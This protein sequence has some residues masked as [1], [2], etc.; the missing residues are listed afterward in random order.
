MDSA[1]DFFDRLGVPEEK[2]EVI[3]TKLAEKL[4][5]EPKIGIFGKTGVGKSS[6]CNALFGQD[7]CPISDIESCTRNPQEV[8]LNTGGRGIKLLDVP[9]VGENQSKDE[10]YGKLYV[11]LLPKLDLVLW[12]LKGDDRAFSSD[13]LFY[14]AIVKPH[15]SEGK[16]FFFVINQVDKIEPYKEWNDSEHRPGVNQFS[17][18]DKKADA[19]SRAFECPKSWVIPVSAN[20][21]YNLDVLV[22]TFIYALPKEKVF[23]VGRQVKKGLI[24]EGTREKIESSWFE[25]VKEV[26]EG[27]GEVLH[28]GK[29]VVKTVGET[30]WKAGKSIIKH[31]IGRACFITTAT[32]ESLG[33]PDDCYE[34]NAFRSFRDNWL[35][36]Q[37]DGQDLTAEYYRI[38]PHIVSE[39]NR[40]PDKDAVYASIWRNHLAEC[41][42]LIESERYS[43]CKEK[44]VEMVNTLKQNFLNDR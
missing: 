13:E 26:F 22:D 33:R 24:S 32:C 11:K 4:S 15:I 39:I 43:D 31:T 20:E 35:V 16:T 17:N 25:T 14:K 27:V 42:H 41:L 40:N 1:D 34:L 12:V 23:T 30:V 44:Y 29:E 10:E 9:G 36:Q 5:Y 3:K 6:L 7:I 21:K 19:V 37:P 28:T 8:I 18:I 38:A 2:R